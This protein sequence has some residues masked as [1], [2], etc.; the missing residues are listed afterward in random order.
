MSTSDRSTSVS[1]EAKRA[2]YAGQILSIL[3]YGSE[4]WLLTEGMRRRLHVS[5]ATW[6]RQI[7]HS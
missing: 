4:G 3:L 1:L 6:C 5:N 7:R 2:V